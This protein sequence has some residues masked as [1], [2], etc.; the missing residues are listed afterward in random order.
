MPSF[1]HTRPGGRQEAGRRALLRIS[2]LTGALV[3]LVILNGLTAG[4]AWANQYTGMLNAG[5][6]SMANPGTDIT[7]W[8]GLCQ[9]HG[10]PGLRQRDVRQRLLDRAERHSVRRLRLHRRLV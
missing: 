6:L 1:T 5:T 9:W 8:A 3:G 7:G 10:R 4:S 2:A